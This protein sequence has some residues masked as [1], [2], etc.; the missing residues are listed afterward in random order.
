MEKNENVDN[1]LIAED[2]L[3]EWMPMI[4]SNEPSIQKPVLV[5]L[6]VLSIIVLA[7]TLSV[8][9]YF[10]DLREF[11]GKMIICF[12]I[13]MICTYL[14]IP[15]IIQ[16]ERYSPNLMVLLLAFG[17]SSGNL[18]LNSMLLN[19]YFRCRDFKKT[20]TRDDRFKSFAIYVSVFTAFT[21]LFVLFEIRSYRRKSFGT[22]TSLVHLYLIFNDIII[23]IITAFI[24]RK[25]SRQIDFSERV[26][27]EKEKKIFYIYVKLFAI[28]SVTWSIQLYVTSS[29]LNHF[30]CLTSTLIMLFSAVNV[31][32]LFLGR[33]KI[34]ELLSRK[35]Y[36]ETRESVENN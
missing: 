23:I 6:T 15:G 36:G 30:G 16:K 8:Y 14:I 18:W 17:F 7:S 4:C 13:S 34:R 31:S 27:L 20:K 3:H 9:L 26:Q 33:K 21:V 28:M 10:P 5:T 35:Y 12:L 32:G 24:I 25:I 19:I 22:F 1:N 11:N 29:E 2:P